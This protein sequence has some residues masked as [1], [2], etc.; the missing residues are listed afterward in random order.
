MA[1]SEENSLALLDQGG[2]WLNESL[3]REVGLERWLNGLDLE[4]KDAA[5]TI[6]KRRQ[7]LEKRRRKRKEET[8]GSD[9]E[10][11]G[12]SKDSRRKSTLRY[13]PNGEVQ[14][15]SDD[16]GSV[17][18]SSDS[19]DDDDPMPE[20]AG[21]IKVAL[22]RVLASGEIKRGEYSPQFDAHDDDDEGDGRNGHSGNGENKTYAVFTFLYRGQRQLQKMGILP[23]PESTKTPTAAKRRSLAA[24]IPKL[25]PL[26]KEGNRDSPDLEIMKQAHEEKARRKM[27]MIW[28]VIVTERITLLARWMILMKMMLSQNED[29]ITGGRRTNWTGC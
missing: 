22:F 25:G 3:V 20:A 9:D 17:T 15:L 28:I 16:D 10:A 27:W 24:E 14:D 21:Q 12:R 5:A 1:G 13:G 2:G 6:E 19:D 23:T 11:N 18:G 4:G 29:F 8:V 26:K 7:K